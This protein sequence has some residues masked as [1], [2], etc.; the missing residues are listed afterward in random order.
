[1]DKWGGQNERNGPVLILVPIINDEQT[2]VQD[3]YINIFSLEEGN[4]SKQNPAVSCAA[5][6]G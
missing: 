4:V 3:T 1:M 6:P 2:H 5:E